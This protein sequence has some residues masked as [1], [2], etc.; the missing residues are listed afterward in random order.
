MIFGTVGTLAFNRL[1]AMIDQYAAADPAEEYVI[2]VG[3]STYKPRF[4]KSFTFIGRGSLQRFYVEARVIVTHAG[5]G[6]IIETSALG[7][8]VVLVPRLRKLGECVDDHQLQIAG[9]LSMRYGVPVVGEGDNLKTAL[10]AARTVPQRSSDHL[11]IGVRIA[12]YLEHIETRN[13]SRNLE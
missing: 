8:P 13:S 11:Q 12:E 7:K 9:Y 10:A 1:V 6:T 2:Q 5:I 3:P 4:A